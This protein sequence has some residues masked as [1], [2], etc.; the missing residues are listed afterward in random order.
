MEQKFPALRDQALVE[1]SGGCVVAMYL[2]AT[3]EP[4]SEGVIARVGQ[5]HLL[6]GEPTW[7]VEA[8]LSTAEFHDFLGGLVDL[9]RAEMHTGTGSADP[10]AENDSP[11]T[12]GTLCVRVELPFGESPGEEASDLAKRPPELAALQAYLAEFALGLKARP[13]AVVTPVYK[14]RQKRNFF[15]A[16]LQG[17]FITGF[18]FSVVGGIAY[19]A[20]RALQ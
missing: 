13:D 18:F 3:F 20:F 15:K 9:E 7:A 4:A 5:Q 11:A 17:I 8:A 19:L 2:R 6:D 16:L 12:S 10:A 14:P 1:I